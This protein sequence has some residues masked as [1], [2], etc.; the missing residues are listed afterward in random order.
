MLHFFWIYQLKMQWREEILEKKDMKRKNFKSKL[1]KNSCF[2]VIPL[3]R[4]FFIFIYLDSLFNYFF[5]FALDYRCKQVNGWFR[6][7]NTKSCS[8]NNS[9][10][11]ISIWFIIKTFMEMIIVSVLKFLIN[12]EKKFYYSF[13]MQLSNERVR[14]ASNKD[15]S[16]SVF[17]LLKLETW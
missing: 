7:R 5:S 6:T 15:L 4:Y 11:S 16:N 8:S 1:E 9:W 13:K 10:S 17:H 14:L 3:G 12:Y 2:Y